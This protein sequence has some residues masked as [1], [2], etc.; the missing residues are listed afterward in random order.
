MLIVYNFPLKIVYLISEILLS[1][2]T[3]SDVEYIL[4]NKTI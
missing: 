1:K 4:N 2:S 3:N